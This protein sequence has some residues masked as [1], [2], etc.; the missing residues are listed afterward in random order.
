VAALGYAQYLPREKYLQTTD[1]LLDRM[2][3]TMGG[4]AAEINIFDKISTGAQNDLDQVTKMA[5][6]MV[7]IYGMDEKIGNISFY[8]MMNQN[9]FQKPYSDETGKMIDDAVREIIDS[10]YKRAIQLLKDKEAEVHKLANE[11]L[12][13]EV[14]FKSDLERLIGKRPAGFD[15][16]EEG[17]TPTIEPT[18]EEPKEEA[19]KA[20]EEST[21]EK[22]TEQ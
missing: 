22:E 21:E 17:I 9:N 11:L 19:S 7:T 18:E 4:R 12:E 13:K 15:E 8:D 5:Y 1:E 3:M 6:A 16:P 20:P 2:C 14:L 10:Q